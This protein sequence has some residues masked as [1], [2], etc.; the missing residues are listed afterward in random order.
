MNKKGFTLVELLVTIVILWVLSTIGFMTYSGYTA[1]TRDSIR[2][3]DLNTIDTALELYKTKEKRYPTPENPINIEYETAIAWTQGIFGESNYG[4]RLSNAKAKTDPLTGLPYAYAV[5]NNK[6][7]YQT[8]AVLESDQVSIWMESNVAHAGTTLGQAYV[9]WNYNGKILHVKAP[10]W[11]YI[12]WVPSILA[13]DITSAQLITI[14]QADN[15]VL[16]GFSNLPASFNES[17]FQSDAWE[18][19]QLDETKLELFSW[20]LN[21][22]AKNPEDRNTLLENL[23]EYYSGS[24]LANEE[25]YQ[26][27]LEIPVFNDSRQVSDIFISEIINEN[28]KQIVSRNTVS[29]NTSPY[30][31]PDLFVTTW[32]LGSQTLRFPILGSWSPNFT[33]DWWDSF[34][35]EIT[36]GSDP[37]LQHTY[38]SLWVY[39][40]IASW[41]IESVSFGAWVNQVHAHEIIDIN[42]WWNVVLDTNWYQFWDTVNLQDISAMD[43]P[44]LPIDMYLMQTFDSSGIRSGLSEWD[45]SGVAYMDWMFSNAVN[46][47]EDLSGW[48]TWRVLGCDNFDSNTDSNWAAWEKPTFWVT[49]WSY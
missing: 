49:C 38:T 42:Q 33:I 45:T 16:H 46:F 15:F 32:D 21:D 47:D 10:S 4:D 1:K 40:V 28:V 14:Y 13:S 34:I 30:G 11:D 20:S 48:D 5:T 7:E 8:A 18:D 36:S 23:Q 27:L 35:S 41:H 24:I 26:D 31:D 39:T 43:T 37:D 3:S 9:Q 25:E 22:L 2:I 12:L 44:N 19:F 6:R 17:K 29:E